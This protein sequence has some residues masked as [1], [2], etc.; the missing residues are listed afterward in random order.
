MLAIY[1]IWMR[2]VSIYIIN[3]IALNSTSNIKSNI[4]IITETKD[5]V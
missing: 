5:K 2:T 1:L 3:K 4:D